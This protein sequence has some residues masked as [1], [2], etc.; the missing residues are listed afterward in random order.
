MLPKHH[1]AANRNNNNKLGPWQFAACFTAT[2]IVIVYNYDSGS[3][4]I[5]LQ[6]ED[7]YSSK[8]DI[9]KENQYLP[10]KRSYDWDGTVRLLIIISPFSYY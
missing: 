10:G 9:T 1:A 6:Q 7:S 2:V 4:T 5:Y 8:D 3:R